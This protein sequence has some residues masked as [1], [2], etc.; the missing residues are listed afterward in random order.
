LDG[1]DDFSDEPLEWFGK[2]SDFR[3]IK[4]SY[5][6]NNLANVCFS[7]A[8]SLLSYVLLDTGGDDPEILELFPQPLA[9]VHC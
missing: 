5:D 7:V 1:T 3:A 8:F 9:E 2:R 4:C 6:F